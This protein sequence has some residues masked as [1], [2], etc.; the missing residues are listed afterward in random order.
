MNHNTD[1][2]HLTIRVEEPQWGQA[3]KPSPQDIV[4]KPPQPRSKV[5][6]RISSTSME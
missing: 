4:P 6:R 3:W 2:Q 1:N 5:L